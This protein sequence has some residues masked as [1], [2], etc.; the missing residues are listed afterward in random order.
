MLTPNDI[1]TLVQ[2]FSKVFATKEDLKNFATKDDLNNFAKKEDLDSLKDGF[3]ALKNS[4][5]ELRVDFNHLDI[6]TQLE[7]IS[8]KEELKKYATKEEL[9]QLRNDVLDRVDAVFFEVKNMRQEQTVHAQ[10][11]RDIHDRLEAIEQIPVISH[12]LKK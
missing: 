1:H 5:Q 10:Q 4:F 2:E 8:V 7:I 9:A 11:H 12:A 6:R 3:R